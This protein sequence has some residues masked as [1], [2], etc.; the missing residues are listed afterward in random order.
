MQCLL[1]IHF[2]IKHDSK[3]KELVSVSLIKQRV[4]TIEDILETIIFKEP[5]IDVC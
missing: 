5:P 3:T 2:N 1:N 4:P